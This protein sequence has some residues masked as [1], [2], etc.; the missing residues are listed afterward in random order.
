MLAFG[1][2][3]VGAN[4][5]IN[6][7]DVAGETTGF[8]LST[9]YNVNEKLNVSAGYASTTLEV[10]GASDVDGEAVNVALAYTVDASLNMGV[11]VLYDTEAEETSVFAYTFYN[12]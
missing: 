4:F 6:D 2:I 9:G 11:D 7:A 10:T 5:W 8:Y 1:D 12:F 3:G